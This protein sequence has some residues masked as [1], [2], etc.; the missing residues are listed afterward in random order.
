MVWTK[1]GPTLNKTT[2]NLNFPWLT[3]QKIAKTFSSLKNDFDDDVSKQFKESLFCILNFEAMIPMKCAT[4]C[5]FDFT[6]RE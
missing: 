4:N 1:I 3:P 5:L 6:L 2:T